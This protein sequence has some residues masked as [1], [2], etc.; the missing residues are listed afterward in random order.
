MLRSGGHERTVA[1]TIVDRWG[2]RR[3]SR[4]HDERRKSCGRIAYRA[5][6]KHQPEYRPHLTE[7]AES[8]TAA[9]AARPFGP[10]SR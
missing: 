8:V 9:R 4:T 2:A 1:A 3:I 6:R 7:T 5:S 10:V